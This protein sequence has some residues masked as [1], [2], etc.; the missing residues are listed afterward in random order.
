MLLRQHPPSRLNRVLRS[1][2]VSPLPSPGTGS[3]SPL[4]VC[5]FSQTQ[6][7]PL[8]SHHS[9]LYQVKPVLRD[10]PKMG[11][12]TDSEDE[13]NSRQKNKCWEDAILVIMY[14]SS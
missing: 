11:R 12:E 4:A 9:H 14:V 1:P 8:Y 10:F 6:F 5:L 7:P 3:L 2:F 13:E